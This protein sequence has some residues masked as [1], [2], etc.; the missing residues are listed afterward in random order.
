MWAGVGGRWSGRHAE[1]HSVA[2]RRR[3]IV[4]ALPHHGDMAGLLQVAVCDESDARRAAEGGADRLLVVGEWR[5][6]GYSPEP[7]MVARLTRQVDLPARPL[8]RLRAG[9]RTDGGEVTR[10]VGLI[11]S[12]LDSGAEGMVLG[13]LDG[14]LQPDVEVIQAL[15]ADGGWPWSFDRAI[16]HCLQ[17]DA[18][19]RIVAGQPNLDGIITAGSPEGVERGLD[20]LIARARKDPWARQVMVVGGGLAP[21]HVAWLSRAGVR[22]FQLDTQVRPGGDWSAPVD[23]DL[24]RSWRMLVD[25]AVRHAE[26]G[27][28]GRLAQR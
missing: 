8:L 20:T 23:A 12:Y 21:E 27:I 2:A 18:A 6:Q 16:D 7:R 11:A 4:P 22:A 15:I 24:V 14:Y 5:D 25:D 19:W 17:Q 3:A 26:A 9:F 28:S 1:P 10:L 13:F